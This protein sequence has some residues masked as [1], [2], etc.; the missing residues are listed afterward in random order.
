MPTV[1]GTALE[2]RMVSEFSLNAART[3]IKV[4]RKTKATNET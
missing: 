4:A 1:G 3:P 2:E